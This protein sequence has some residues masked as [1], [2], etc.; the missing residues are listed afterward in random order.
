MEMMQNALENERI[1][2]ALDNEKRDRQATLEKQELLTILERD[3]QTVLVKNQIEIPL[4]LAHNE[5]RGSPL[6]SNNSSSTSL[7]LPD[8]CTNH[9]FISHTQNTGGDQANAIYLELERLGFKCW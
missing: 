4:A 9:F 2:R 1:Q 5:R 8:G 3:C 6:L 7:P